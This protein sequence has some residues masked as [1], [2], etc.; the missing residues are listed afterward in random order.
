MD[1]NSEMNSNMLLNLASNGVVAFLKHIL[2][3]GENLQ[4]TPY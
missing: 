2:G 4:V 3:D 1:W